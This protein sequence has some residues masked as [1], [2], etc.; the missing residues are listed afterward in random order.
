[1]GNGIGAWSP[2]EGAKIFLGER[3][4]NKE[5]V[6]YV[7]ENKDGVLVGFTQLYPFFSSTRMKRTWL[8]NDL[9]VSPDYRGQGIS[10]QLIDKAKQ[11]ASRFQG[12]SIRI[13]DMP[14]YLPSAD[15]VISA[16]AH[17]LPIVGKGTVEHAL[18]T[19]KRR[20]LLM[21]DMAVPRDIE[22]EI[23][24]LDDVYLYN[25]DDL[26]RIVNENLQLRKTAAQHAEAQVDGA[27][28]VDRA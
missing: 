8:L 28:I 9:Y 6:I 27:I 20:P 25:I 5:S 19:R 2:G 13:E 1:M 11:L 15:I 17:P 22:P 7:C 16:T 21:I 26:G 3:I 10:I 24:E 14:A 4:K 23:A 18:R 12:H